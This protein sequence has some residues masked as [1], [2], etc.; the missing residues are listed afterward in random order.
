MQRQQASI[1][2]AHGFLPSGLWFSDG[3]ETGAFFFFF[4]KDCLHTAL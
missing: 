2:L 1:I 4:K 3:F